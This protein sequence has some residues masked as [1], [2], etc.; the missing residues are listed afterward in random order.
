MQACKAAVTASF[1]MS[2]L[3]FCTK[4]GDENFHL[5]AQALDGSK[6]RDL[7]SFEGVRAQNLTTDKHFP[8]QVS[9]CLKCRSRILVLA[10]DIPAG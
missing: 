8:H 5:W 10:S 1:C 6:P 2:K 7:T 9:S 3:P 4:G